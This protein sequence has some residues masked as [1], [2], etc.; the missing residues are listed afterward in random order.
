M[1]NNIVN[2]SEDKLNALVE[3]SHE[4]H[5]VYEYAMSE[6]GKA[7]MKL[8]DDTLN[9]GYKIIQVIGIFAGFGFTAIQKVENIYF[10]CL[11]EIFYI[12]AIVYGIYQIKKIY[13]TNLESVQHS[14]A[15]K[16]KVFKEKSEFFQTYIKKF[17][18]ENK[19]DVEKFTNELKEVDNKL[20][21][22]FN[23]DERIN[24]KNED[25]FLN[26]IIFF[27]IVGGLFLLSSFFNFKFGTYNLNKQLPSTVHFL[28]N[29]DFWSYVSGFIGAI[30]LFFFGLPPRVSPEGHIN[31]VL[32]QTNKSEVKKYKLFQ[33]LSYLSLSLVALSFLLQILRLIGVFS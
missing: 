2:L 4:F 13:A 6:Y 9:F 27:S 17:T 22:E 23:K 32:E 24:K 26:I 31:L 15:N 25:L 12:S 21:Q 28:Q 3:Q 18:E 33:K 14:S 30:M 16:Y 11:G 5:K 7:E 29:I 8:I 19:L 10:F 1:N 20:L